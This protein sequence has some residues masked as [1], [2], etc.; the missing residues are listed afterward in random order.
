MGQPTVLLARIASIGLLRRQNIRI[1][2]NW[3]LGERS[4]DRNEIRIY[5]P[6]EI[7]GLAL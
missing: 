7:S 4:V 1:K 5:V 6:I 3:M 2:L